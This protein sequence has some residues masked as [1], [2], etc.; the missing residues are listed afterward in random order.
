MLKNFRLDVS[1]HIEFVCKFH[2]R[3]LNLVYFVPELLNYLFRGEALELSFHYFGVPDISHDAL[4]AN[5]SPSLRL[6]F[7]LELVDLPLDLV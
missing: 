6:D 5:E 7:F 4:C 2:V 3:E 1:L